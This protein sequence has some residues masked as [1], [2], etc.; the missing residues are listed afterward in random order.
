MWDLQEQQKTE[1]KSH[2]QLKQMKRR[3][4]DIHHHRL[5]HRWPSTCLL[6][7]SAR[8]AETYDVKLDILSKIRTFDVSK[9][10]LR[11]PEWC[12]DCCTCGRLTSVIFWIW[13]KSAPIWFMI[14]G[15]SSWIPAVRLTLRYRKLFTVARQCW[16]FTWIALSQTQPSTTSR[17]QASCPHNFLWG[18]LFKRQSEKKTH[19]VLAMARSQHMCW[20][21]S[22][23]GL[24]C[25]RRFN[26][27]AL[28][29]GFL[30]CKMGL[31]LL[32]AVLR[33]AWYKILKE[34]GRPGAEWIHWQAEV[35]K[36]G[37]FLKSF[38]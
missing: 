3:E 24:Q 4:E 6:H 23:L 9:N 25:N 15:R 26:L 30:Q 2:E 35:S 14:P 27:S 16:W 1:G 18:L 17:H 28:Y 22:K 8:S 11:Q 20:Q 36:I 7:C 19:S 31:L 37:I 29:S 33:L 34:I 21:L 32:F 38:R 5:Q 12:R 10:L 13:L